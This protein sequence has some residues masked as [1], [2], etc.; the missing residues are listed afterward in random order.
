V[1]GQ[2]EI[3]KY[4]CLGALIDCVVVVGFVQTTRLR[5]KTDVQILLIVFLNHV[6]SEYFCSFFMN[7]ISFF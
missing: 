7:V 3:E 2:H 4:V 6:R 1:D 5:W